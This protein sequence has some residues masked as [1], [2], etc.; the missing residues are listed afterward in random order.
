MRYAQGIVFFYL[1]GICRPTLRRNETMAPTPLE[2]L[3]RGRLSDAQVKD[4]REKRS[5]KDENGKPVYSHNKLGEM[6]GM[7]AGTISQIVR[8]RSYYDPDYAPQNDPNQPHQ[9]AIDKYH[10]NIRRAEEKAAAAET[11][12]KADAEKAAAKAAASEAKAKV[13]AEKAAAKAKADAE[14][15]GTQAA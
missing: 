15:A 6:F 14:K 12:A 9:S 3:S 7:K 11:K 10:E 4:I 5:Q 2:E 8:N 13:A 1:V